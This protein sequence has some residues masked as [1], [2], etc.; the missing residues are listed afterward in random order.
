MT[1]ITQTPDGYLWIGTYNGLVRFDGVRF[2]TFDPLNTSALKHAR[3]VALFT[4]AHGTLWI[5]TYDGSL[6]SLRDGVFTHE[7]QG[8]QVS[9]VFSKSNQVFIVALSGNVFL[10]EE[11]PHPPGGWQ[12]VSL[13]GRATGNSF[14]QD[15]A[16][17]LW[18][19]YRDGTMGCILGTN[20]SSLPDRSGLDGEKANYLATD[21]DGQVWVG[22]E[23]KIARWNGSFFVDE[24]PT[25]GEPT[26]NAKLLLCTTGNNFWAFA[27]G[28]VRHAVNR[29]WIAMLD[30]WSDLLQTDPIYIGTYHARD[31]GVWI[32]GLGQGLF[33][34]DADGRTERISAANG[35]P[36]NRVNCWFQDREGNIWAGIDRGG[37]VRLRK[38]QFQI[39]A[40][41][42]AVATVCEDARSNIW[43]GTFSAGLDRWLGGATEHFSLPAATN[44]DA[45]FSTCPDTQ[46]RLWLS[47]D[48]EDLFALENNRIVRSTNAIHGIKSIL[49]DRHG[50]IWLGR[51]TQLT[52]L[53]NG[54]AVNYGQWNGFA[55]TDV[56]TLAE[57]RQG[58]IWIGTGGG[59]LYKYADGNFTAFKPD[60]GAENQAIW[61]VL[62]D[63]DGTI[64]IGTF[65]GGLLRFKDGKFTRY[66]S[67]DGLPSDVICQILD[68]GLG[69]LWFG[70]HK[71]IFSLPKDSF[72]A[73]DRGKSSL[74]P[75]PPMVC[76]MVCRRWNVPVTTNRP[77]GAHTTANSG[78]PRPRASSPSG[79]TTCGPTA[80][81][82]RSRWRIFSWT[83]KNFPTTTG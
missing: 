17:T 24:T 56:R 43:I 54:V 1:A 4:D 38:K 51:Q 32:R 3:I 33:H 25:N 64:W 71:G 45:F 46:G 19:L 8:G 80:C 44:R 58:N 16:G 68:D 23:K 42:S 49:A 2:V 65:R 62:P 22:T 14:R 50:R 47:A 73:F 52:C 61:S 6:T 18:Y 79:R 27:N 40:A 15:A 26:V 63:D 39:L 29:Q 5:N 82:R 34:A 13:N 78:S 48:H 41:N 53:T 9:G 75:A 77:L 74:C 72:A 83:G 20:A 31:G 35:L 36:G 69:K 59:V 12:T 76:L 10:R 11:N 30:S 28:T 7:W 37:L 21:S 60:G 57:D 55:R 67:Q 66:T 70:S 81:R